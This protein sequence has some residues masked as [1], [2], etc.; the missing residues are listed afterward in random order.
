MDKAVVNKTEETAVRIISLEFEHLK[1]VDEVHLE[2]GDALTVIGGDNAQGKSSILDGIKWCLGGDRFKPSKPV[3]DGEEPGTQKVTLSNGWIVER[4]GKNGSLRVTTKDG[5]MGGQTLLKEF[6][7]QFALDLQSFMDMTDKEKAKE[8][9]KLIGVD[10]TELDELERTKYQERTE[11]G[12]SAKRLKAYADGLTKH[13][14]APAEEVSVGDLTAKVQAGLTH[15]QNGQRAKQLADDMLV[16]INGME[17]EVK[18]LEAQLEKRLRELAAMKDRKKV[19][20]VDVKAFKPVDIASLQQQMAEAETINR[21]V[22]DNQKYESAQME[23][24]V[25]ADAHA[26]LEVEISEIREARMSM[27]SE[28]KMPLE[29]LGIEDEK[30]TYKGQFWDNMSHSEQLRVA[31]AISSALNPKCGFVLIDKI[32]AMDIPT[33]KA[34]GK[35]CAEV[36]LQAIT[37]RVSTGSECTFIIESGKVK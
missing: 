19:L 11:A 25:A 5:R 4:Y 37:T 36:G 20:D 2:I 6:I 35:Y 26:A 27:L 30:L 8:L 23:A 22:R 12:A 9:L 13:A 32:E 16:A 24:A 7:G 34:F 31:T 21:M 1:R 10:L 28:A 15:N 14:D 3:K 29:G 18:E 33:L 17:S